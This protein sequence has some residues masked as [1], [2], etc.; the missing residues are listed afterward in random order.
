MK[1]DYFIRRFENDRVNYAT[2]L[3]FLEG[4][5]RAISSGPRDVTPDVI[6][7]VKRL[8]VEIDRILMILRSAES[9]D[10]PRS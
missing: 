6:S 1:V 9:G 7:G 8:I 2:Q 3:S 5:D 4:R 10:G